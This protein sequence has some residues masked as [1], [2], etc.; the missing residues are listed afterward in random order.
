MKSI[1][2]TTL[3][4]GS[5]ADRGWCV[6]CG[7]ARTRRPRA[8]AAGR[9]TAAAPAAAS[10][11]RP[12]LLDFRRLHSYASRGRLACWLASPVGAGRRRWRLLVALVA[13]C[14]R[15]LVFRDAGRAAC[16]RRWCARRL[17]GGRLL[18]VAAAA[19]LLGVAAA[20]PELVARHTDRLHALRHDRPCRARRRRTPDARPVAR[21]PRRGLA[22][23]ADRREAK[24][25][26][27]AVELVAEQH[28]D[29][30]FLDIRMPGTVRASRRRAR[31]PAAD[32][33][34]PP[35]GWPG[36]RLHHRLRPVRDRGLRA[37]RR[38]LRAEAGR[39]RAPAGDRRAAQEAPGRR[40]APAD[41][42]PRARMQQRPQKLAAQV[43]P[44]AQRSLKWIQATRRPEHPDDPGRG[45]AVLHLRREV[46]AGPDRDV[47][48]L[49]RKP[50]KEL[51]D[52]VDA[53]AVLA[54]PPLD[55]GQ[56]A[57]PSPASRATCAGASS[58]AV[59]GP[60]REARGE[61]QLRRALQGD[62]DAR[63]CRA[64]A[65]RGWRAGP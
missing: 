65:P 17:R 64:R 43:H 31:S 51:V 26:I 54:D 42:A 16:C 29:L 45:R 21:A 6:R 7:S 47:E 25:G 34:T 27:E 12:W 28:P 58:S 8:V 44:D 14:R 62:V 60:P 52:E 22:R 41:D 57:P 63:A 4:A 39:A 36:D 3:F 59:Q 50:I 13:W 11:A 40:A 2:S 1:S 23:T 30:V 32:A 55:A 24:N 10:T 18:A 20:P 35:R 49:I 37:G 9:W 48:A 38:R 19:V 53:D 46:H 33:T 15:L 5:C 61:P 56:R